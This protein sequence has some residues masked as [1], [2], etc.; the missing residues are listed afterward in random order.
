[1]K[2]RNRYKLIFIIL[3]GLIILAWSGRRLTNSGRFFD[4]E[5]RPAPQSNTEIES[6]NFFVSAGE[7]ALVEET[8]QDQIF[9]PATSL[10]EI[11]LSLES[12]KPILPLAATSTSLNLSD[13]LSDSN[14]TEISPAIVSPPLADPEEKNS[15]SEIEGSLEILNYSVPFT[16]QAPLA[17]W[18]DSRQQDGCEEAAALMAMAWLRDEPGLSPAAWEKAIIDL[19]NWQQEKY[20][21]HRDVSLAD[22]RD[23]IFKDYFSYQAV[24]IKTITG[25]REILRELEQGNLILMPADG[26]ALKNPHYKSPGPEHHMLLIKGYDYSTRE[27]I[28]NDPGTR[29]GANYRYPEEIIFSAL[30]A[31][32][33]GYHGSYENIVKELL[34]VEK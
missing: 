3:V 17:D 21:E 13:G 12:N 29:F 33:T 34:V 9:A 6:G 32:P 27:F 8:T 16:P 7:D 30:S 15:S 24:R 11:L 22:L 26:R 4:I 20:G 23:R 2:S 28:T 31:Y 10:E 19:A 14:Q 1:M 18:F 5:F 25:P